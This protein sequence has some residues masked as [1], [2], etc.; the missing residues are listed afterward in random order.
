[1]QQSTTAFPTANAYDFAG[2][3]AALT[4][5]AQK[6]E[7]AEFVSI[8]DHLVDDVA[9][10]SSERSSSANAHSTAAEPEPC[11]PTRQEKSAPSISGAAA[12]KNKTASITIR[13]SQA[14]CRQLRRRAAEA[15]LTVSA[16]L[17]SCTLEAEALRAQV[18]EALAELKRA[19]PREVQKEPV[20]ERTSWFG[21]LRQRLS[22]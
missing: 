8:D 13:M 16:Y 5:P 2:L 17:R 4:R 14:E 1:M 20:N 21:A 3:L 12:Q 11:A 6:S 10:L 15:G 7:S 22:S 19:N 9:T 18:K